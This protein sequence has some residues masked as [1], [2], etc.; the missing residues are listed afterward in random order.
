MKKFRLFSAIIL[1][2][3]L[4][5]I[6]NISCTDEED[7]NLLSINDII[8]SDPNFSI[9]RAAVNRAG[10]GFTLSSG[11][12]TV[13]A[14]DNT[15][16][17]ASGIN[18][19]EINNLPLAVLDDILNYHIANGR[20]PSGN[21]PI[22]DIIPSIQGNNIYASRNGNGIFVNGVPVIATDI[23]ATNGY[24]HVIS[25]I[26][27]APTET[28][29]QII[30]NTPDYSVMNAAINRA[31]LGGT[32]GGAGKYTLFL[33]DNEAFGTINETVINSYPSATV[34]SIVRSHALPTNVFLS[35]F[36]QGATTNS[37]QTGVSLLFTSSPE[38]VKINGSASDP[39]YIN[40]SDIIAT[41]G[42]IHV[43]DRVLE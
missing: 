26:M 6:S 18:E 17:Q 38:S 16:F 29:S 14:P 32:F 19:T 33:P 9:L 34:A 5:S 22:S 1:P 23:A 8:N 39:A 4:L 21:I 2:L 41:N 31:N 28:I 11:N 30:Q 42:V 25:S 27:I 36:M 12:Y 10:L 40:T 20:I 37:L 13:F 7:N 43:V 35:D 24:I 15:A 3:F